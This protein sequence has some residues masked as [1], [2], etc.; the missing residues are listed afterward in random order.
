MERFEH[1]VMQR[2]DRIDQDQEEELAEEPTHQDAPLETQ[3]T[4]EVQQPPKDPQ[5]HSEPQSVPVPQPEPEEPGA[6]VD[7]HLELQQMSDRGKA[8]VTSRK[9][10]KPQSFAASPF[11]D[12]AKN[13]LSEKD[14]SDQQLPPTDVDRFPNLYCEEKQRKGEKEVEKAMLVAKVSPRTLPPTLEGTL[15]SKQAVTERPT[16]ALP[17]D[18]IPNPK[19]ECKAIQLRSE[20]ILVNDKKPTEKETNKKPVENDVGNKKQEGQKDKQDQEKLK[21]KEEPQSSKKEKQIM[22]EQSQE[23]RK[24]VK[25]YTPPLPHPQRLQKEIKDQ[26][27]PKFL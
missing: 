21:E 12:Y 13:P 22:E 9:R 25:T 7:P 10:K 20:R 23:Q 1:R 6:I 26:Q 18:T 15:L 14:K 27:F 4:I 16:N 3:A 8:K 11:T 24:I 19:E 17:S 2:L 5:P